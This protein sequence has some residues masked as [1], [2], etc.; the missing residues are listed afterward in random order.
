MKKEEPHYIGHKKRLKERFLK[1]GFDALAEHEAVEL[2][3]SMSQSRRD[4]K[5]LAK[6]LLARF[7]S[8]AGILDAEPEELVAVE[9]LGPGSAAAIKLVKA[10]SV[11]YLKEKS[12]G[13]CVISSPEALL[14]YCLS[15][16]GGLKDEEFRVIF[17]NSKNEVLD[18]E[19]ICRGTIDQ[20]TVY[21]RKVIE[22][23]IHHG[24]LSLIFVHNHPSGHPLPSRADRELTEILKKAAETIQVKIHDHLIIGKNEH[25]SFATEGLL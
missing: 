25:Y 3:L 15:A 16:M 14:D 23:A 21:P 18:D 10:A 4:V 19:V 11:K 12:R 17:L 24:A 1:G 5:E 20:T 2:I 6:E 7:S 13:K 22:R 9:G 8:F